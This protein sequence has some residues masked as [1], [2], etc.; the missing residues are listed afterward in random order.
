MDCF[1]AVYNYAVSGSDALASSG[2]MKTEGEDYL[3]ILTGNLPERVHKD[4]KH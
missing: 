3:K 2:R 1:I 4:R